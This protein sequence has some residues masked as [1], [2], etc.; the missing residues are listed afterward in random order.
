[1]A[2]TSQEVNTNNV[3]TF[4]FLLFL[5]LILVLMGNRN[6]F[7]SHFDLLNKEVNNINSILE[8]LSVTSE[9]LQAAITAP[10]KLRNNL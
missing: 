3:D 1:M 4:E 7:S 2:E 5:I 10:Q 9:G 6:T 8:A